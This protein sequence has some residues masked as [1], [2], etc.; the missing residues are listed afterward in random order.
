V[1]DTSWC[2]VPESVAEGD[3]RL[4]AEFDRAEGLASE[5][6]GRHLECRPGCIG[7]CMGPFDIT[8]L[9]AARLMRGLERLAA[10][11][12]DVAASIVAGAKTSWLR[13]APSFPG[14]PGTG[15]LA[16]DDAAREA[17]FSRFGDMP[18]PLLNA[19]GRCHLYAHR[20]LSCR[21]F[22]YPAR[23]GGAL[24]E[25][26]S[27]NFVAVA[28]EVA[29]AATVEF[30][31]GDLEGTLLTTLAASGPMPAETIVCAVLVSE[32]GQRSDR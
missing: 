32:P 22:G 27:L 18:C 9:D 13:L 10:D 23:L 6:A 21:S 31:P 26:C 7:C 19:A 24:L 29:A 17:F 11:R 2:Q 14:D 15:V 12:S 28:P 8:V 3:R 25:P 4:V 1:V 16:D 20:P 30:D 5:L